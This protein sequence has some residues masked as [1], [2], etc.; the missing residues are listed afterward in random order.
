LELTKIEIVGEM[1]HFKIPNSSKYQLTYKVPP[2]STVVGIL[3]N[4]YNDEINNFTIGCTIEYDETNMELIKIYK[5]INQNIKTL[6]CGD[7]FQNDV[8]YVENIINPRLVIYTDLKDD[9]RALNP[10]TLGKTN[11]LAKINSIEKIKL[12]NKEGQ[13]YNQYTSINIGEGMIKRI[14][15]ITKYNEFKGIYQ[16]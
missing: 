12:I 2:I 6:T 10:L 16:H 13:G 4:I 15:T 5:E 9:I 3:Q 8:M 11:Y 1:A 7:R 14:N